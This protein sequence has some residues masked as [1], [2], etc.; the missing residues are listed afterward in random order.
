MEKDTSQ[1][2]PN[3]AAL[4]AALRNAEALF[5]GL[6]M[7]YAVTIWVFLGTSL[8]LGW[9]G[10]RLHYAAKQPRG[11]LSFL[12]FMFP[13]SIYFHR[14][15][16]V[17]LQLNIINQLFSPISLAV[18]AFATGLI[19]SGT[20]AALF[21]LFPEHNPDFEWSL[22]PLLGFTLALA[23]ASDFATYAT[24]R[25]FHTVPALWEIH[26]VHHSAEVLTPLTILRKHP[27]FDVASRVLKASLMGPLQGMLFFIWAGPVDALTAF[28]ANLVF[29]IFHIFGAGLRHSH[30]WISYGPIVER[31]VISPAQHQ[32]HHS[33]SREHWD[34]NYGMMFAIWDWAFGS[35]Y[36]PKGYEELEFGIRG[37]ASENFS[38]IRGGLLR[39]VV[40]AWQVASGRRLGA[41]PTRAWK[42]RQAAAAD[43]AV[44]GR[45]RARGTA[46]RIVSPDDD[47]RFEQVPDY[48]VLR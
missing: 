40:R 6:K 48:S 16:W 7:H 34:K 24:H 30:V 3:D 41:R 17:D 27:L 45:L 2:W 20:T 39:P 33:K 12:R 5:G 31:I 22:W 18:T 42:Q 28:G 10:W 19:A 26:K 11:R 44:G 35:L 43:E 13:R 1:W 4:G 46:H 47:P 23:L 38:G 14:S 9:I 25:L 37:D 32:I 15:T 36:I 29:T 8:A 21:R